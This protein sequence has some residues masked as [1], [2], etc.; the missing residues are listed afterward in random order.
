VDLHQA[1]GIPQVMKVLLNAGLLHGDCLTITGKTIA[2]TLKD[3]P[4]QPRDDQDVIRT[5]DKA[6]YKEGHLAILK[7]NLSPEGAVAKITGLIT[8]CP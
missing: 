1:G 2:E 7:G 5:I 6:M 8:D 3:I 4:D